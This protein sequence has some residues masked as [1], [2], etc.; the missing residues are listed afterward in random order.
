MGTQL[1][2]KLSDKM[3]KTAKR[4]AELHGYA[5]LQDFIREIIRERLFE[6]SE[7]LSGFQTYLASE[8]A[9]E[10]NWLAKG[11]EKAWAHLQKET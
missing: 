1:S 7:K 10:K 11:E 8:K 9:L 2:L 5:N 6:G 3:L 4:Y